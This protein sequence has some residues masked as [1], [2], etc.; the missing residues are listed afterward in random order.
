VRNLVYVD[1]SVAVAVAFRETGWRRVLARYRA[2]RAD[3]AGAVTSTLLRT[4]VRR[5][6]FRN[7]GSFDGADQAVAWVNL[8]DLDN[9]T[10]TGAGEIPVHAKTLDA[11]H[12]SAPQAL[13]DEQSHLRLWTLDGQMSR[14]ASALGLDLV[15][16]AESEM[17]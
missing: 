9:E 2:Q 10:V 17:T 13:A 7:S 4:E 6:F 12:L 5:V 11:L 8:V 1:S 15:D 3:G 16:A 14:A